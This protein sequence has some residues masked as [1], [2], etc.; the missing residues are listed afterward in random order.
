M[1][2]CLLGTKPLSPPLLTFRHLHSNEPIL[3]KFYLRFKSF[4]W[5]TDLWKWLHSAEFVHCVY[6]G[7]LP[8]TA[9]CNCIHWALWLHINSFPVLAMG[10]W[11]AISWPM[12]YYGT[13]HAMGHYSRVHEICPGLVWGSFTEM[14]MP[15]FWIQIFINGCTGSCLFDNFQCIQWWQFGQNDISS[16]SVFFRN[17]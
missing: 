6:W 17:S 12:C 8:W 14:L 3:I 2:H 9:M 5:R 11:W 16:I 1:A 7:P 4:Q 10:V 13:T 15:S